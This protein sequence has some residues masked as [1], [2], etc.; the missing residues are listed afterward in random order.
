[1]RYSYIKYPYSKNGWYAL[2]LGIA[3][4]LL[5]AAVI[6]SVIVQNCNVGYTSAA[7]GFTC[8]VMQLMGLWFTV[9]GIIEKDTKKLFVK[10]GGVMCGFF[11]VFW[12]VVIIIG[13]VRA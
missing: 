8:I 7:L 1:M 6:V 2:G 3:G 5:T 12:A 4:L 13:I 9:L 11:L 10:I